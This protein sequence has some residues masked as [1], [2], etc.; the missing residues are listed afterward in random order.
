MV[1]SNFLLS[2]ARP[3]S[4]ARF[5][6]P[7]FTKN[8]LTIHNR[9]VMN[10]TWLPHRVRFSEHSDPT[11]RAMFEQWSRNGE[12]TVH[13]LTDH[14]G[15]SQPAV[16]KHLAIEAFATN[17]FNHMVLVLDNYFCHRSR[18]LEMKDGNPLNETRMLRDSIISNNNKMCADRTIK[19]DPAKSV[20]KHEIGDTI[21]L[22]EESFTSLFKAFFAEIENKYL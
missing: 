12:Q 13:V 5:Q 14:S 20:L 19:Y 7:P 3:A 1:L 2:A 8:P 10:M 9:L 15:V 4:L 21:K 16:S 11:R 6:R 18:T 22:N 17:F